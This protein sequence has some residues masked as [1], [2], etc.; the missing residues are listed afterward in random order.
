MCSPIKYPLSLLYIITVFSSSPISSSAFKTLPK[1]SS[2]AIKLL[3]SC[4]FLNLLMGH[5]FSSKTFGTESFLFHLKPNVFLRC[6]SGLPSN[7]SLCISKG[8]SGSGSPLKRSLCLGAGK[9]FSCTA[10]CHKLTLKGLLGSRLFLSQSTVVSVNI[11]VIY[12]FNCTSLP[13]SFIFGLKYCPWPMKL[14]Q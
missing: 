8:G 13:L 6:H 4:I 2:T 10:L 11:S 5:L 1:D 9:C 14:N 7:V 3:R 12:P